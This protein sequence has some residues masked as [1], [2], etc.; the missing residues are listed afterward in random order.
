MATKTATPMKLGNPNPMK[1]DNGEWGVYI[2]AHEGEPETGEHVIV[3]TR[4]GRMWVVEIAH[5]EESADGYIASTTGE[6]V[7]LKGEAALPVLIRAI[8]EHHRERNFEKLETADVPVNGKTIKSLIA[9][10]GD[11]I[12]SE[13]GLVATYGKSRM[14]QGID[15]LWAY[16]VPAYVALSPGK[17]MK[18]DAEFREDR[19]ELTKLAEP[20]IATRDAVF[21]DP[22]TP[23]KTRKIV[24]AFEAVD[25]GDWETASRIFREVNAEDLAKKCHA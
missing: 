3:R 22:D 25:K 12:E 14:E 11:R 1:L 8:R 7:T 18:D 20:I 2:P 5:V 15:D 24:E 6:R 19:S 9:K 17:Q 4:A 10:Y 16:R 21:A 23:E 13:T